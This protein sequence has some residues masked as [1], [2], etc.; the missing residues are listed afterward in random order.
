MQPAAFRI[1]SAPEYFQKGMNEVLL[2]LDGVI[3]MMDD[4]F[5]YGCDQ[6]EHN[7]RLMAVLERLKQAGVAL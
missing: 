1:T 5:V 3:C 4:I 6:G 2:G 7:S